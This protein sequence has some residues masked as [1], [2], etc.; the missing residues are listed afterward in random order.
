[1]SRLTARQQH[2]GGVSN[3]K[4]AAALCLLTGVT[5]LPPAL[6]ALQKAALAAE[7]TGTV[8]VFF[9]LGSNTNQ[10]FHRIAQA[11][12]AFLGRAW[13]GR[14]WIAYSYNPGFVGRLEAQGA[15]GVFDPLLLD[16]VALMGCGPLPKRAL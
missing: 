10:N 6:L 8:I 2:S 4:L 7:A 3:L 16:P 12:G 15:W 11:G 14:A 9:P 5:C 13:L 1:M